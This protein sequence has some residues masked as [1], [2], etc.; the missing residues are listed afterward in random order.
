M[1]VVS[2][3]RSRRVSV[4]ALVAALL[5]ACVA[6]QLNASVLSPA[7]ASIRH[8]L[9]VTP[10]AVALTRAAFF[11]SAALF[12]LFLPRLGGLAGRKRV[13]TFML[14]LPAIGCLIA[15]SAD[16]FPASHYGFHPVFW[17]MCGI[18]VGGRG[19]GVAAGTGGGRAEEGSDGLAGGWLPGRAGRLGALIAVTEAGRLAT[20]NWLLIAVLVVVAAVMFLVFWGVEDR[21]SHPLVLTRHLRQR[22][23]WALLLTTVFTM[24]GV[25]AVMNGLLLTLVHDPKASLGSR[26]R[27]RPCGS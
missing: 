14:A 21:G 26:L 11:S 20:A 22:G 25:F 1:S 3:R 16:G 24:T 19:L 15:A 9:K 12:S 13:L 27:S 10:D 17:A 8:E 6:F 4:G 7:L 23:T 5:S 2:T 18:A